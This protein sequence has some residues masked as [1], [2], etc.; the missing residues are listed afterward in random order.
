MHSYPHLRR[1]LAAVISVAVLGAVLAVSLWTRRGSD[2]SE[3]RAAARNGMPRSWPLFG[4]SLDRNMVNTFEKNVPTDFSVEKGSEKNVLW[5]AALGSRSYAGPVIADG[6]IYIGTNRAAARTPPVPGDKGVLR[7]YDQK[8]GKLIWQSIHDKLAAGLVHD[9]PEQGICSTPMVDGDRVYYVSNRCEVV[10]VSTEPLRKGKNKGVTDEKYQDSK[11]GTDADIIWRLDMMKDLGVFP[12]NLA[13]SCP[14]IIDDVLYV[15]TSNGVDE[16]HINVP[17]PRAPSFI[18]V[19]KT[20]GK[21]LWQNN[22]PSI[23]I[24]E[25]KLTQEA[26][27]DRGEKILHGQWS[28]PVYARVNGRPQIIFPGGDGWLRAFSPDK[29]N[30]K[31]ELVWKFDCNPKDS[32]WILQGKGT[33]NNIIAAPVVHDNKVYV[34]VGQDPEHKYGVGHFWCVDIT[35]TGD[36]SPELVVKFDPAKFNRDPRKG[37]LNSG[38]V[39]K[40]NPNSAVVWHFGGPGKD[41]E[42]N[43]HIGRTISTAAVHDG[44][45]YVVELEGYI[46]CLDARTGKKYWDHQLGAETWSSPYL[47]AGKVL[48]GNDDGQLFVFEHGKE[49]KD[50]KVIE[51]EAGRLRATPTVLDGVLYVMS[52]NRL[53]AIGGK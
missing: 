32:L 25:G 5:Q 10:C 49:K 9:W 16:G 50:P 20:T 19:D 46:H 41:G 36:L 27:M 37:P 47:V 33:R 35:K 40:P 34:G 12:H 53:F 2:S 45:V 7:C 26:L 48:V 8:T 31:M 1:G 43:Y 29:A 28:S 39:T 30:K 18:A 14:L 15:V 38:A 22:D 42:R 44:L 23:K 11:E 3:A 52:E 51:M 17:A 21:V 4:G 24:T 6:K 13:T